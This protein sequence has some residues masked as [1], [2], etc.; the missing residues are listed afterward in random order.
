M[1]VQTL[2]YINSLQTISHTITTFN[3]TLSFLMLDFFRREC[4]EVPCGVDQTDVPV[5]VEFRCLIFYIE[6]S[7]S[8]TH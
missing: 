8:T 2:K 3:R 6:L 5:T 1:Q 7:R 4:R